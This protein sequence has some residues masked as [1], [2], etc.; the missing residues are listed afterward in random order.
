M[1]R[2]VKVNALSGSNDA[3]DTRDSQLTGDDPG[4]SLI[5][6]VPKAT[7]GGTGASD[8]GPCLYLGP[9][10]QRCNRRAVSGGFCG[11]HIA[12]ATEKQAAAPIS[13]RKL[14]AII[15]A[16]V[17]LWPILADVIR[18]ILRLIR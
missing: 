11:R 6:E 16:G 14:I 9:A 15:A 18:A 4:H 17:A 12:G 3:E 10:G 1:E 2:V 5:W 13:P 8:Q 7:V